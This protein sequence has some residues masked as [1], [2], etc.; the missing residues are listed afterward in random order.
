MKAVDTNVIIHGRGLN[1]ELITVPEVIEELKSRKA[2]TSV[3]G[4]QVETYTP[5]SRCFEKVRDKANEI[6]SKASEVDQKLLALAM[7]RGI[8]LIT[9]DK[10]LQN[11][12]LHLGVDVSGFLDPVT[13][14]KLTWKMVCPS[15]GK[16]KGCS[17]G[18]S[19]VRKLDRRNSV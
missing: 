13:E 2:S 15:C 9:D 17:C 16:E 12:G 4:F 18:V 5:S 1:D 6:N 19:L 14:E 7:E 10:E 3:H 11:L 8:E